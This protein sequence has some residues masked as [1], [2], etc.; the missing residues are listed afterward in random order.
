[1]GNTI[2]SSNLTQKEFILS[3]IKADMRNIKL[4]SGLDKAG[5]LVEHFYTDLSMVIL[6]LIGFEDAERT[7]ELYAFYDKK[8]NILIDV[9]VSEFVDQL[10]YK[11]VDF[12]NELL[13]MKLVI[14]KK[15]VA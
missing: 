13:Y 5:A 7:D 12:Y 6:K 4:I 9:S 15:E 1:M 10:N 14:I 3:L 8:M 2:Y 11:A